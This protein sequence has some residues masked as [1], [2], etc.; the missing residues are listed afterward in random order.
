MKGYVVNLEQK[1]QSN[2]NFRQ[3]LFTTPNS[4][5]VLM[6]LQPNE[7]IGT[8]THMEHDQFIRVESGRGKVIMDG[9]ETEIADGFGFV[10]PAGVEHNVVN[11]SGEVMK[12]YTIYTPPEHADGTVHQTK[13]E[14]EAN[15]HH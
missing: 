13:A 14:A 15:S 1:T 4:Q 2:S 11:T 7:E 12:L 6:A 8:E 9:E 3:V 10:I 5:L